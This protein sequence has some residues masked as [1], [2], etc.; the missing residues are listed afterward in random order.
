[1]AKFDINKYKSEIRAQYLDN[2]A[3]SSC[4]IL[5]LGESGSGKT[6][7]TRTCPGPIWVDSFD[8]GGSKN[9]REWEESGLVT[10]DARFE[11]EDPFNPQAFALWSKEM[12]ERV[13]GGFFDYFGTYVLDSATTWSSAIMNDLLKKAGIPGETPRWEKEYGPL[14]TI[15]TNWIRKML[16][17][18]CNFI[19]T[20]HLKT[21]KDDVSGRLVRRFMTTGQAHVTIPLLF[22]EI[23][24][25]DP[26]ETSRGTEYRVLTASTG[27]HVARSRLSAGGILDK[28]EEPDL[29]KIFKKVGW[30]AAEPKPM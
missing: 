9:L 30:K 10:V 4:N 14:K 20:G 27:T 5:L 3:N 25:M 18:P 7:F 16:N 15:T 23:W 26:K 6:F 11:E 21:T 24:V 28:Y 19:L 22:D 12:R 29:T 8:R 13:R 17:M 1:M 2:P